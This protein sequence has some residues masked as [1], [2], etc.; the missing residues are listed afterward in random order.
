MVLILIWLSR[1]IG[2]TALR[3]R[4]RFH[5]VERPLRGR[6][7]PARVSSPDPETTVTMPPTSSLPPVQHGVYSPCHI[8]FIQLCVLDVECWKLDVV[9]ILLTGATGF[10]GYVEA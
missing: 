2:S 5:R 1:G 8:P 4:Y 10:D 7:R 9:F 6:L 3:T